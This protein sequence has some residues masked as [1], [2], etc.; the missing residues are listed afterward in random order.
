MPRLRHLL[1]TFAAAGSII[2]AAAGVAPAFARSTAGAA[3]AVDDGDAA[4]CRLTAF[5]LRSDFEAGLDADG[6]WAG[7]ANAGMV[8]DADRPFRIRVELEADGKPGQP[9]R[10]WLQYRRNGGAWTDLQAADFPY[11]LATP[12][13]SVVSNG[14]YAPGAPTGDLLAG[15]TAPFQPGAG[16]VL[17]ATTPGWSAERRAHGEWE[18]PLVVRRFSDHAR[19]NDAGDSYELRMADAFGVCTSAVTPVLTV[20]VPDRLLG[21]TFVETPGP[22][23]PWQASNGDLYFL[24]EPAE[25]SNSLMVV[26]SSDGGR[27]WREV[28]GAHR[29]ATGDLEGVASTLAGDSLHILHQT[30]EAV[31]HHAF[32]TA[33]HPTAPDTWWVRDEELAAPEEPPVQV[34]AIAARADGNLVAAYGT[35]H[36]LEL[37]FRNRGGR[38]SEAT[39]IDPDARARLSGPMLASGRGGV[40]HMAYTDRDGNAWY[41]RIGADG[42]PGPRQ[43]VSDQ[44]GRAD[45]DVGSVLPLVYL[46]ATDTLMVVY[47]LANGGLRERRSV[48][49]GPLTEPAVVTDRVV[50]QGAVDSDQAGADAVALQDTAQVLFIEA[51]SGSLFHAATD[52]TGRWQPAT[53]QV[54]DIDGQWVR[55][56]PVRRAD[57]TLVYGYVYDAGSNGGSGMNRYGEVA[58]APR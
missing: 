7:S 31:F 15:S 10:F 33:D 24:M 37:R 32:R 49:G 18:W 3:A 45:T 51:D 48:A 36:G 38:W 25:T 22:I 56:R 9:R 57:G 52:A 44:L 53:L 54:D 23:G 14:E 58:P 55:G 39:T 13:I 50:V 29:P 12:P 20:A 46:P 41:R 34:A 27:S 19:T 17:E 5:R 21:G 11:P 35:P 40:V 6:G 2:I 42:R 26:K 16:V 43:R 47:R 30:S 1:L 8:V 4:G 28:D